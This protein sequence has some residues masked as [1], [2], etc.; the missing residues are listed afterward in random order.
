MNFDYTDKNKALIQQ[1][2][3]FMEMHLYPVETEI[4]HFYNL[5]KALI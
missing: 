3:D 5:F 1:V 4:N 2:K